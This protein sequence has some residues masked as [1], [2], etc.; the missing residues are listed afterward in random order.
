MINDDLQQPGRVL[1]SVGLITTHNPKSRN[2]SSP[3][4]VGWENAPV[5]SVCQY[6]LSGPDTACL[7]VVSH[8]KST[9]NPIQVEIL[10]RASQDALC[11]VGVMTPTQI[12]YV[13]FSV[14]FP[15]LPTFANF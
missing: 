7:L 10:I 5:L 4:G 8:E 15:G 14:F 1:Y 9:L 13:L 2:L 12:F 6:S 11:L 3:V